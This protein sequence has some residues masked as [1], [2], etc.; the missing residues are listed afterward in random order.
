MYRVESMGR[1]DSLGTSQPIS[2]E[3]GMCCLQHLVL[4]KTASK[5]PVS[6]QVNQCVCMGTKISFTSEL[7]AI[8]W[9]EK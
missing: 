6:G 7:V 5:S 1:M 4:R 9:G 3:L 8:I 2:L